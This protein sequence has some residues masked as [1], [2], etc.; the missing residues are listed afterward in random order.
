MNRLTQVHLEK[1][2]IKMEREMPLRYYSLAPVVLFGLFFQDLA[3]PGVT[4]GEWLVK[5]KL[6]EKRDTQ[7]LD[8]KV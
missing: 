1:S 2:A 3:E 8:R 5:E 7:H 6:R 4:C